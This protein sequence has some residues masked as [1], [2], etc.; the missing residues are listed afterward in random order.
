MKLVDLAF[1]VDRV[2]VVEHA[3]E[4]F[5]VIELFNSASCGRL[6]LVEGWP[7]LGR[8]STHA[9]ENFEGQIVTERRFS[10]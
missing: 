10:E 2:E 1:V 9:Q 7:G 5:P 8:L 3:V 4:P 6:G